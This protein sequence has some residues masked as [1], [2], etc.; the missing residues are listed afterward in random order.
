MK[1]TSLDCG[2]TPYDYHNAVS[3]ELLNGGC[4]KRK[5]IPY[6]GYDSLDELSGRCKVVEA[7]AAFLF[8]GFAAC[9][10]AAVVCFLAHKRGTTL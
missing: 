3:N 1:I 9:L 6:C 4:V 7:D 8:L 2:T 10:G 5:G